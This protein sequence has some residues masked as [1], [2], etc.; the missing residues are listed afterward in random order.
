MIFT[1]YLLVALLISYKSILTIEII[2]SKTLLIA[3]TKDRYR[4]IT[5]HAKLL[6]IDHQIIQ[7]TKKKVIG[8]MGQLIVCKSSKLLV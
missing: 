4:S 3:T 8:K 1:L 2:L 7:N 5:N 6:N